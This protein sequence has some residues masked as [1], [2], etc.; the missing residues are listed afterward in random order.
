[1]YTIL[2]MGLSIF[3]HHFWRSA[4]FPF[5]LHPKCEL[6]CISQ[7]G[8]KYSGTIY[9]VHL[10]V[11][12]I[13]SILFRRGGIATMFSVVAPVLVY[14]GALLYAYLWEKLKQSVNR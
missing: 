14:V 7:I 12:E 11:Y 3:L 1:M 5:F 2:R 6:N 8:K 4:Y 10:M 9:I 13:F